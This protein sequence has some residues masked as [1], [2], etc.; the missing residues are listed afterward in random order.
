[1]VTAYLDHG[2]DFF[3]TWVQAL[4]PEGSGTVLLDPADDPAATERA[5]HCPRLV[6]TTTFEQSRIQFALAHPRRVEH[7]GRLALAA[8]LPEHLLRLQRRTAQRVDLPPTPPLLCRLAPLANR[9]LALLDVSPGGIS[10]KAPPDCDRLFR[11]GCL[12]PHSAIELPG[13]GALEATLCV[14]SALEVATPSGQRFLRV[15]CEFVN[16][17]HVQQNAIERLISQS[18]LKH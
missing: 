18:R 13:G 8:A 7:R 16:L 15:G 6:L 17:P 5:T 3:Q 14:R 12:Y 11:S 4:L 9:P 10:L 2:Q 1:M